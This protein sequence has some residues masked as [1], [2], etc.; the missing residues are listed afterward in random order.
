MDSQAVEGKALRDA[1]ARERV[2]RLMER[3]DR[4]EWKVVRELRLQVYP[5]AAL[6]MAHLL[7][8]VDSNITSLIIEAPGM[9]SDEA[10]WEAI[11][12]RTLDALVLGGPLAFYAL[13]HLRLGRGSVLYPSFLTHLCNIAPRLC[14]VDIDIS[15][16]EWS[17]LGLWHP[18]EPAVL[19]HPTNIRRLRICS[20]YSGL[21]DGY[22]SALA[23]I[24][25]NSDELWQLSVDYV[26]SNG[27]VLFALV[28]GLGGLRKLEVLHLDIRDAILDHFGGIQEDLALGVLIIPSQYVMDIVSFWRVW[29]VNSKLTISSTSDT[30]CRICASYTLTYLRATLRNHLLFPRHHPLPIPLKRKRCSLS[31]P[32]TS[33]GTPA[34][35]SFT[36]SSRPGPRTPITSTTSLTWNGPTLSS[37]TSTPGGMARRNSYMPSST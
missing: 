9:L 13:T 18:P 37:G 21:D 14:T 4:A 28:D 17:E 12:H 8:F 25:E 11:G 7:D 26:S 20:D 22:T 33:A 10:P 34:F 36:L 1:E 2:K 24:L 23:H 5:S 29:R 6:G 30:T 31:L 32:K 19:S 3:A 35:A 16:D 27:D 15:W